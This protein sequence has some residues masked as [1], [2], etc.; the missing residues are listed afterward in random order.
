MFT[1]Y[2]LRLT[3]SHAKSDSGVWVHAHHMANQLHRVPVMSGAV[4]KQGQWL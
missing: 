4:G 3:L 1:A 2:Y